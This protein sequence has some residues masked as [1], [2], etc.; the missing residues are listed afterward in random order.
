KYI[1][2]PLHYMIFN[3]IQRSFLVRYKAKNEVFLI[4]TDWNDY[5]Y[6]TLF[7]VIYMD[8]DSIQRKVGAVKIGYFK[9]EPS[10]AQFNT[11]D[12][13]KHLTRNFFSVGADVSYY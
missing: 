5:S 13:F 3:V 1:N 4:I 6:K 11:G 12:T 10:D 7:Q 2:H 9:H 8:K